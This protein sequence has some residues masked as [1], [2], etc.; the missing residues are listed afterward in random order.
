M[1]LL[2]RICPVWSE[3]SAPETRAC[4]TYELGWFREKASVVALWARRALPE[5][6]NRPR[7]SS[8]ITGTNLIFVMRFALAV[9]AASPA[10]TLSFAAR[11]WQKAWPSEPRPLTLER[12]REPALPALI[13]PMIYHAGRPAQLF[14]VYS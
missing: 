14:K 7:P 10:G 1:T 5:V 9:R 13:G 6:R 8:V 2:S 3:Q 12:G 4:L 11:A